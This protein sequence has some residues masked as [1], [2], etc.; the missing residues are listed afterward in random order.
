MSN[1]AADSRVITENARF[2]RRFAAVKKIFYNK[3]LT[4]AITKGIM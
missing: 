3:M 4:F 2:E 1:F